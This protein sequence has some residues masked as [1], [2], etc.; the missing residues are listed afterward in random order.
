M[1]IIF[2][3]DHAGFE[4]KDTLKAFVEAKGYKTEDVGTFSDESVDYP[5][6]AQKAA[7]L[8]IESEQNLGVFVCGTGV[9]ISI[10][11]NKQKGIRAAVTDS[12]EIAELA[13]AHNNANVLCLGARFITEDKA[14]EILEIF[15]N[16]EFEQGR[17]ANRLAKLEG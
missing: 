12:K 8:V 9:G 11:A 4:L 14:K 13:S 16:T 10:A 3:A 17:H 6:F 7:P 2:A 15:L 5:D 1:K